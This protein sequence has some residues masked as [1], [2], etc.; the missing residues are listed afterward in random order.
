MKGAVRSGGLRPYPKENGPE[1]FRVGAAGLPDPV[2]SAGEVDPLS[3]G[4]RIET[5][6]DRLPVLVQQLW[7]QARKREESRGQGNAGTAHL[8]G[9]LLT[10]P[11]IVGLEQRFG[12]FRGYLRCGRR[13]RSL[14]D[15]S[16]LAGGLWRR[17]PLTTG[18]DRLRRRNVGAAGVASSSRRSR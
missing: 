2:A 17:R 11:L 13:S 10:G 7:L 16:G 9:G 6:F 15:R 14:R 5:G 12:L 18:S 3:R 4:Q 8:L 1:P